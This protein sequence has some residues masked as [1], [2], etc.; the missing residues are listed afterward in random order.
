MAFVILVEMP[1]KIKTWWRT[2]PQGSR[3]NMVLILFYEMG[4]GEFITCAWKMGLLEST[5][6]EMLK[7]FFF[8]FLKF[9]LEEMIV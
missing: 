8:P 4:K 5:V 6:S 2:K 7:N 9:Q 1:D 3:L